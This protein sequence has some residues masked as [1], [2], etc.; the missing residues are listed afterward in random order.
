MASVTRLIRE[1]RNGWRI[2]FYSDKRQRELYLA[3]VSK[4]VAESV[5]RHCEEL[6]GAKGANTNALPESIAWAEGTEGKLRESLVKWGLAEPVSPRTLTHAGSLLGPFVDDY[7]AGR[8]D[9]KPNTIKNFKQCRR[10]LCEYFGELRP[11]K[12]INPADAERWRRKML[13]RPLAIATV[14]KHVKRA[15]TIFS[16]AVADRLLTVSPFAGLKG[17]SES[18]P[19]R[20]WFI[21]SATAYRV[22]RACPDVDWRV[23]FALARFAGMRCPSEVL[24][25]RWTDVDWADGRL[26][27]DSPKTGLRFCPL[28]PELREVLTEALEAAPDGAVYCV[29][30]YRGGGVNL[31]TQLVRILENAGVKPWPK[32]FQNLRSSRRT[33]LQ[34]V[35]PS[36]VIN[37]WLA[38]STKVAEQ[39]YLTVTDQHWERAIDSRPLTRP[40]ITNGAPSCTSHQ[41]TKKPL[42]NMLDDAS[43]GL[44][45]AGKVPPQG[46]EQYR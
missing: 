36:H 20:L 9:C 5:G 19:D 42:E 25:I 33:E 29:G 8:T 18:N 44:V 37:V 12:A 27:I 10:E 21:D 24:A 22:L 7:I 31:R 39:H 34:E 15:K 17:G 43:Q 32:L 16:E 41:D 2:R 40:L 35:Y 28:F 1:G 38:Q 3:G 14:S 26:R 11:L 23:L 6:S 4:K 46:L 30:R 45:M 13:A